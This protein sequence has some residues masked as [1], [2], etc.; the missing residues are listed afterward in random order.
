MISLVFCISDGNI[1]CTIPPVKMSQDAVLTC[2]FPEDLNV[3]KK[4]FAIY[5]YL[6]NIRGIE[7]V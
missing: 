1:T 6:N 5:H 2:N 3:T 4:D 7:I